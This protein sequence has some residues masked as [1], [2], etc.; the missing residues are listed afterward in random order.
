MDVTKYKL[1]N[2]VIIIMNLIDLFLEITHISKLSL[3]KPLSDAIES[4]L[5][6]IGSSLN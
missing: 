4:A 5:E 6:N 2:V 3:D 1:E